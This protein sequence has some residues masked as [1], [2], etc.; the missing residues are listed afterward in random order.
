MDNSEEEL[1]NTKVDETTSVP[2]PLP[3]ATKLSTAKA[4]TMKPSGA[5]EACPAAGSSILVPVV[6]L[7]DAQMDWYNKFSAKPRSFQDDADVKAAHDILC[8]MLAQASSQK[9]PTTNFRKD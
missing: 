1:P 2:Q 7:T 9:R 5:Q 3:P 8:A 4:S 6:G